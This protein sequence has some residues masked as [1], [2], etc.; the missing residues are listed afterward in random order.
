MVQAWETVARGVPG[1][2]PVLIAGPTASGKSALAMAI[3]DR[4]GGV[5]INADALQVYDCWDVLTARPSPADEAALPHALYGHI[6]HDVRHSAGDWLRSVTPLLAGPRLPVI[7]GGTGLF[8]AAL[9][10]GLADIP[11]IAPAVRSRADAMTLPDLQAGLDVATATRIDLQNRARVQRGWEVLHSTG[12]PLADWQ[13]DTGTAVL[14]LHRATTL[15]LAPDKEWLGARIAQRFDQM[16]RIGVLD[17]VRANL[18]L[19]DPALPSMKAIGAADLMAHLQGQVDL[20]TA[21]AAAILATRQYARMQRKW[22]RRRM[23]D[24]QTLVPG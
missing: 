20:I 14:P 19:W 8:F 7:V 24:W 1:D 6:A 17:E 22:L 5:V 2:R 9:T 3:A 4:H 18:P 15:V 13:D 23:A 12:R 11:A 10:D 21:R 16:L